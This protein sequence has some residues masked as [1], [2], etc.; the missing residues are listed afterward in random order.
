MHVRSCSRVVIA[1]G[2]AAASSAARRCCRRRS[3]VAAV[4]ATVRH[5]QIAPTPSRAAARAGRIWWSRSRRRSMR[6][7]RAAGAGGA[8]RAVGV[9]GEAWCRSA[10]GREG[11]R[12]NHGLLFLPVGM[13]LLLQCATQVFWCAMQVSGDGDGAMDGMDG[14]VAR[15]ISNFVNSSQLLAVHVGQWLSE[16][17]AWSWC[18]RVRGGGWGAAWCQVVGAGATE[19]LLK[20]RYRGKDGWSRRRIS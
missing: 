3:L 13:R 4:C 10:T 6:R 16:P 20:D 14:A 15:S 11:E 1:C 2:C 7:V 9:E 18:G 12:G 5:H 19:A 17:R 8:V